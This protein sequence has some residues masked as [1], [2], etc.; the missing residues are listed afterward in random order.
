[1]NVH[2]NHG[3]FCMIKSLPS[4]RNCPPAPPFLGDQHSTWAMSLKK[5]GEA[6]YAFSILFSSRIEPEHSTCGKE[7]Y[8]C[9]PGSPVATS[10]CDGKFKLYCPSLTS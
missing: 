10:L 2:I 7:F 8:I 4:Q 1:M 5:S 3:D 6:I 9:Q